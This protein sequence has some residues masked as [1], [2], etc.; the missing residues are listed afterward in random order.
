MGGG[1]LNWENNLLQPITE[2]SAA[3]N[4]PAPKIFTYRGPLL[5][6]RGKEKKERHSLGKRTVSPARQGLLS[7]N[8]SSIVVNIRIVDLEEG[9]GGDV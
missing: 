9:G 2:N 5:T 3:E 1:D 8:V 6:G 4:L 7:K